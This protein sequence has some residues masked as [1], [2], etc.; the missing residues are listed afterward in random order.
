[1][2]VHIPNPPALTCSP[3]RYGLPFAMVVILELVQL[4]LQSALEM[5]ATFSPHTPLRTGARG[6]A[7]PVLAWDTGAKLVQTCA[8]GA[9]TQVLIV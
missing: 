7:A 2:M 4:G 5:C 9:G 1:M 8:T 6:C 3:S